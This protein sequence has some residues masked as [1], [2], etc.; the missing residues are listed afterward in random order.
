MKT[1]GIILGM[2]TLMFGISLIPASIVYLVY[3]KVLIGI[4]TNLPVLS[5]WAVYGIMVVLN[6]II[7]MFKTHTN[8]N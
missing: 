1:V 3:T 7:N 6:I 8:E 4:F 2:I 5:F